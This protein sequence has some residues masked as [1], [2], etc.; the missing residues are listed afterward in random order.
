M[1]LSNVDARLHDRAALNG[2]VPKAISHCV[3]SLIDLIC[4]IPRLAVF[5]CLLVNVKK[6]ELLHNRSSRQTAE[7]Q[8][9]K[10]QGQRI[11]PQLAEEL[12][13]DGVHFSL[14]LVQPAVSRLLPLLPCQLV[15]LSLGRA[16]CPPPAKGCAVAQH[17][18][19]HVRVSVEKNRKRSAELATQ[20]RFGADG[21][22]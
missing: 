15:V 12:L 5:F 8:T 13:R 14:P 16:G 4:S 10:A 7:L 22:I 1:T 2:V 11:A 20:R 6:G 19:E 17:S 18:S 9:Y 21:A 3:G